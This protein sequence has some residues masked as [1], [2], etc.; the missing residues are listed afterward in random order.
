M[1]VVRASRITVLL[2]SVIV[3]VAGLLIA[4][5]VTRGSTPVAP[6]TPFTPHA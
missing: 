6:I 2:A 5:A 3:F 1:Y 4:Y